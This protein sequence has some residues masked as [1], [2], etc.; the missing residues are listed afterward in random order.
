VIPFA[1]VEV[2]RSAPSYVQDWVPIWVAFPCASYVIAAGKMVSPVG[3]EETLVN[4]DAL[5]VQY[6]VIA[7]VPVPT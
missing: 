3:V 6:V 5:S 2:T 1:V 4:R 7:I